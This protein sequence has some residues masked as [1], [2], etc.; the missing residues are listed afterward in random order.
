MSS[1][2]R[3]RDDRIFET[4]HLGEN[5]DNAQNGQYS[6]NK[7]VIISKYV[8]YGKF[9]ANSNKNVGLEISASSHIP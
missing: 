5:F 3:R 8:S 4:C 1:N 9:P 6:P 7:A 2:S